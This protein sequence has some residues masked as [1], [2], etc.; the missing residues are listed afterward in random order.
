[1]IIFFANIYSN[2]VIVFQFIVVIQGLYVLLT[3]IKIIILKE[4]SKRLAI[5]GLFG[6][7]LLIT[8]NWEDF[9]HESPFYKMLQKIV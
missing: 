3:L 9:V 6:F 8:A 4:K 7:I 2:F 1:M 5:I